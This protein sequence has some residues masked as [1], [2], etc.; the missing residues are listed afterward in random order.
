MIANEIVNM[1]IDYILNNITKDITV[2]EV[3]KH[4]N[5]SR[6]Y[7][8]RMFKMATGEGVYEFIKKTKMEHSAFRLKVE[9]GRSVTDIGVKYGY[10][11]SNYSS[12]FKQ[13][14]DMSP[15]KF[16]SSIVEL[17]ME[18]P[19]F[20]D[21]TPGFES[22]EECSEKITIEILKDYHVIY[23]IP[24]SYQE[25]NLQFIILRDW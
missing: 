14:H 22:L 21:A 7:F 25:G 17:S 10:S 20:G 2:E 13:H 8:S 23:Q 16:R 19:I 3:A 6:F 15:A 5:F 12:T 1:A 4:C 18:N 24:V 11:S 9:K